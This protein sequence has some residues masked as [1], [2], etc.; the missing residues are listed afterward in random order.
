MTQTNIILTGVTGI[1]GS[2]VL[3]ELLREKHLHHSIGSIILLVRP[4]KRN[5]LSA[6][7]RV[8]MMLRHHLVPD[9]LRQINLEPLLRDIT[10]ISCDLADLDLQQ[11]LALHQDTEQYHVI[12]S[13]AT[14]NLNPGPAAFAENFKI[15]HQ[16]SVNL[17]NACKGFL[18]KFTFVSTAYS[19]GRQE[20]IIPN[21]FNELNCNDFRNPYESIKHKTEKVL[22]SKCKRLGIDFQIFR[23]GVIS[24][25]LLEQPLHFVSKYSVFYAFSRMFFSLL[26]KQMHQEVSL[27]INKDSFLHIIPV[28]YVAKVVAGG[29]RDDTIKQMNIVP[30]QGVPMDFL[31]NNLMR[32]VGYHNYK[33]VDEL[34]SP[35]NF[36]EEQYQSI[37]CPSFLSYMDGKA[38]EFDNSTLIEKFPQ[39]KIPDITQH[40]TNLMDFAVHNHFTPIEKLYLQQ[41]NALKA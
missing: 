33:I 31:T 37:L 26:R 13:A 1:V 9:F 5:Q 20:G 38:F 3:Y 36:C 19:C 10:V 29:F 41:Q 6:E 24:G 17:L 28:D 18:R 34:P 8:T 25:R 2:H 21:D 15:N 30:R 14:T 4:D 27:A 23:P 35:G 7:E 32:K 40:L 39:Y 16:G 12:H 22:M 11:K